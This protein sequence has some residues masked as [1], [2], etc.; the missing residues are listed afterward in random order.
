MAHG[1]ESVDVNIAVDLTL[2]GALTVVW[3]AAGLLVEALPAA[4]TALELRR[5]AGRLS[6]LVGVGMAMFVAVP[7]VAGLMPGGSAA[8]VAALV[9]AVPALLVLT[10]TR[11]R[12][13]QVR[14]G[15]GVFAAAPLVP[16]PPALRASAAHPMVAAP[17]QVTGLA[18]IIAVPIAAGLVRLPEAG[19][20]DAG[21]NLAG[22]G[23]TV[24][25]IAVGAIGVRAAL[26]HS[27][28]ALLGPLSRPRTRIPVDV[29]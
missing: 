17:L 27:R 12:L 6:M 13:A 2:I 4:G 29:A 22:V 23:I 24:V 3:L 18:S 16:V 26:R 10:I 14:R 15:A 1:V 8:P 19:V 7:V 20:P 9:P 28:L 5:R 21:H 11:R 25:A